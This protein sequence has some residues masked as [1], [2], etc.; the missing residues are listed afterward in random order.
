M[1]TTNDSSLAGRL[2]ALRVHGST[3]MYFHQSIG[4]DSR[5][6]A[7]QASV[8]SVKLHLD[9]WTAC[10][11]N[12]AAH[13]RRQIEI[14]SIPAIAPRPADYPTRHIYNRLVIRCP[15][16]DRLRIHLKERGIWTEIY[17]L[18]PLH[19]Q[20]C[21]SSPGYKEG[22]FPLSEKLADQ[23]LALLVHV[24]HAP[25]DIDYICHSIRSF[26]TQG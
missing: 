7:L 6:D 4:I 24:E 8:W 1:I 23:T 2:Q 17:Y 13:Y 21:N 14:L 5:L 11:N 10:R 20:P 22:N 3:G 9:G 26:Y 25:D 19:L 15:E 16:R 18:L 12:N